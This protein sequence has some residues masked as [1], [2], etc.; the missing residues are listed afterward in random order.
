MSERF[1]HLY[2]PSSEFLSRLT[3]FE[4]TTQAT[5]CA[6]EM[7]ELLLILNDGPIFVKNC[8]EGFL[9]CNSSQFAFY[10]RPEESD[11]VNMESVNE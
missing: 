9:R 2:E 5:D 11:A 8:I 10:M 1:K 4:P 3:A 6:K 7:V